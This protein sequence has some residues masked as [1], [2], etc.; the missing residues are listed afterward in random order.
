MSRILVFGVNGFSGSNFIKYI[1]KNSDDEVIGIVRKSSRKLEFADITNYSDIEAIIL[2]YKPNF[3]VNF[4]GSFSGDF[5]IDYGVNVLGSKNILDAVYKNR[6]SKIKILLIGSSGEYGVKSTI[7]INEEHPTSPTSSYAL[8]KVFQ[9]ELMFY[10]FKMY[11]LN[12]C[13]V[14]TSNLI[15]PYMS[16][17][18]FIGSFFKQ[19]FDFSKNSKINVGSENSFRD[20][21]DIRD[22]VRAYCGVLK[23]GC[24][25]EVYN[26][27]SGSATQIKTIIDVAANKIGIK[28]DKIKSIVSDSVKQVDYQ[29]LDISKI[30]KLLGF[31]PE[32]TIE[33]SID[34]VVTEMQK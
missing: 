3:I 9:T 31:R 10:Y 33:D 26:L 17:K 13:L 28:R 23:K 2:K 4:T 18:L 8:T 27:G 15:G 29:R 21:I 6:L 22:A 24:S 20:Y 19:A 7:P 14:R 5:D 12:V 34:F 11:K 1:V 32:H 25:G 16:D 30:N